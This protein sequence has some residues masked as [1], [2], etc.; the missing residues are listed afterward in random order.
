MTLCIGLTG[1]IGSGKSTVANMFIEKGVPVIDMD[2]IAHQL[3]EPGQPALEKIVALFGKSVLLDDGQLDR[4]TLRELIFAKS[5]A[6]HQLEQILHPRIR[7][8]VQQQIKAVESPY[9]IIAIPLLL[10]TNQQ[11]LVQRILVVDSSEEHQIERTVK[12]DLC[13]AEQVKSIIHN[14]IDRATRVSQADDIIDNT[15]DQAYL[16]EQVDKLH[17]TYLDIARTKP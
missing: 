15:S 1:G 3:V 7:Q 12:R 11:D 9:C 10:E 5:S 14:Q 4:K 6:R 17:Q 8:E 2:V 13:N 16:Q